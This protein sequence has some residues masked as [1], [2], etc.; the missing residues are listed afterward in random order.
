MTSLSLSTLVFTLSIN[1]KF[2]NAT[3]STNIS[4]NYKYAVDLYSP[5]NQG[6]QY[7]AVNYGLQDPLKPSSETA[8][9]MA[10]TSGF[11]QAGNDP[12]DVDYLQSI[13]YGEPE[14]YSNITVPVIGLKRQLLE[15]LLVTLPSESSVTNK[16]IPE[17][18]V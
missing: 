8:F 4:R 14:T 5:T 16:S 9:Q 15:D 3:Y 6:G 13:F 17:L 12:R 1:G 18:T 10:G 11:N 2:K 7:N